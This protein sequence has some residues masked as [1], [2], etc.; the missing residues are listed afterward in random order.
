MAMVTGGKTKEQAEKIITP[1]GKRVFKLKDGSTISDE[2]YKAR[3]GDYTEAVTGPT[4]HMVNDPGSQ[5][6]A[7]GS[8]YEADHYATATPEPTKVPGAMS[9][10]EK[11]AYESKKRREVTPPPTPSPI[12]DE[13]KKKKRNNNQLTALMGS[14]DSGS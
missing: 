8:H 5:F 9:P 10:L 3:E 12:D 6:G 4:G 2:D 1:E 7:G 13:E 11:A 14:D